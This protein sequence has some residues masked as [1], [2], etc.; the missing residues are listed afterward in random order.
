MS[1]E[2]LSITVPR[3]LWIGKSVS[4]SDGGTF[5]VHDPSTDEVITSIASASGQDAI[6]A[7]D[8]AVAA[9]HDWAATAPRI[10]S[11][12]LRSAWELLVDKADD[13][14]SLITMEMGKAISESRG[15][16]AYGAE[17]LRWFSEEAVRING[18]FTASPSG[19]GQILVTKSPVGP[20]FAITPWNFPL[21]MG[22]RKIGPALAAGCTVIVKP[23]S[24]T[25]LTMLALAA[26]FDEV[27][28]PPGVLSVLPT[29]SAS[30]VSGPLMADAR[31]RKVTFTGSTRVGK[32]LIEKSAGQVL[33]TSMELGGNAPFIVFDDAYI[34]AAVDGAMSA[35]MRN[36]GQACTAAN[37]FIV[38]DSVRE[39]FTYKL[40]ERVAALRIGPG[41]DPAT[42]VGPLINKTQL[43]DVARLVDDAVA[44][45]ARV[46]TGGSAPTGPGWYFAPTVLD[47]VPADARILQEEIF[48][49]VAPIIGFDTED[50]AVSIANDTE[51]GL[52]AYLYTRDLDRAMRISARIGSGMVGINRGIISDPAAPFGGVKQSGLGSEGGSEGIDEYLE[53]K[54]LAFT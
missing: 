21:A 38:A 48:G 47:N 52:A 29:S 41:S 44:T 16:V 40:T 3:G 31:L 53:T 54:Y 22:T 4:A 39:E 51:Y 36:G 33:R 42:D 49:P 2:R 11:H 7:L 50:E 27:G 23:A 1:L 6:R 12:L 37:R 46:R 9:Q 15:E 32:T 43:D 13:F 34:D 20:T 17:F 10:R 5:D 18:R 30:G 35:K 14:A 19:N 24:E 28:L 26:I 25:P 45:G 8:A